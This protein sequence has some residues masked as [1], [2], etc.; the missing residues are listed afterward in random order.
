[1]ATAFAQLPLFK[2]KKITDSA[3]LPTCGADES[4]GYDV[5][6][7]EAEVTIAP[8]EI[9]LM[10][11][12]I[13]AT[14]PAG[15]YIQIAP[16]SG[17]TVKRHLHTLAGVIDPDY[18]GNIIIV[19]HNFGTEPQT[20]HCSDKIAQMVLENAMT[21]GIVE[22]EHLQPSNWGQDGFGSTDERPPMDYSP[23]D[24][25]VTINPDIPT[26]VKPLDAQP[27]TISKAE[28]EAMTKDIHFI[29]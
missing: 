18:Q 15:T 29:F 16:W 7:D 1:M 4:V 21:T 10:S 22:V 5:Y 14:R 20:F 8:G 6:L 25:P 27:P 12:R 23:A 24:M 17:L 2:V 3:M 19:M 9:Q 13:A 11:T 26:P 28:V